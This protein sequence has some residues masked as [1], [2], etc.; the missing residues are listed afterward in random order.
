MTTV[1]SVTTAFTII[2]IFEPSLENDIT[3]VYIAIIVDNDIKVEEVFKIQNNIFFFSKLE[4][5][6]LQHD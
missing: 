2:T 5:H 4:E 3:S 6:L 1:H